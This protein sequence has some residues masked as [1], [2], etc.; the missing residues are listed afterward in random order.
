M[1]LG[2]EIGGTKLQVGLFNQQMRPTQLT[3][4]AVN[5]RAGRVGILRQIQELLADTPRAKAIGVGFGGPV[6]TATGC[7]VKSHQV[8]G[9]D[10]FPLRE[11]FEKGF[12]LPTVVENDTKCATFAEACR[13]A[14]KGYRIVFYTNIGTGIGGGLAVDGR[15][16]NGRLG[17]MELGH[18]RFCLP[19]NHYTILRRSSQNCVKW[20]TVESLAAGLAIERGVSS[21]AEAARWYG[22]AIANAITLLNPDIVIIG[23]GVSLAG[24]TFWRP[25]RQTVRQLVFPPFRRNFKLVP[26]ALGE[27]VVAVGAALLAARR[28]RC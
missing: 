2:I 19:K 25:L 6:D 9:W 23:G 8:S 26:A 3:R 28:G 12:G 24:A 4:V 20:T 15:L 10:G 16:Y 14:G 7:V 1:Y 21:V 11:W 27:T 13:G 17:S 5:R 18:T 22:A